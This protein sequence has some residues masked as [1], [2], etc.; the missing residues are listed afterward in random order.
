MSLYGKR[1]VAISE[2]SKKQRFESVIFKELS[3]SDSITARK[4]HKDE[5]TFR[6]THMFWMA[7]NHKPFADSDDNAFWDRLKVIEFLKRIP[8]DEVDPLLPD[9]LKEEAD[10]IFFWVVQ[11]LQK[12]MEDGILKA[13]VSVSVATSAYR[14]ELDVLGEFI[15]DCLE[16]GVEYKLGLQDMIDMYQAWCRKMGH[17]P[18]SALRLKQSLMRKGFDHDRDKHSG[19]WKGVR[20]NPN[21]NIRIT[22]IE[23]SL[24]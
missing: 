14:E 12:W 23:S 2:L 24:R 17:R 4:M 5:V 1:M 6:P 18:L 8:D 19:F 20:L 3:G 9:K 15:A 11:G 22:V 10:G 16:E 13:P 7:G 21:S